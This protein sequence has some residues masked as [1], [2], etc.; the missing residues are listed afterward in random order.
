MCWQLPL[1]LCNFIKL[2]NPR[3][4]VLIAIGEPGFDKSA[5]LLLLSELQVHSTVDFLGLAVA[6]VHLLAKLRVLL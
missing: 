3:S 5:H 1:Q 2:L 4:D 6:G